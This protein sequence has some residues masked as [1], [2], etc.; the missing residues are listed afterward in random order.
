[1][2]PAQ[3]HRE[4]IDA[5][6]QAA[7]AEAAIPAPAAPPPAKKRPPVTEAPVVPAS[8]LDRPAGDIG[9]A[10]T[11]AKLRSPGAL[12][13]LRVEAGRLAAAANDNIDETA[14]AP[15]TG[16][17]GLIRLQLTEDKRRLKALE[18]IEA[19]VALKRELLSAYDDYCAIVLEAARQGHAPQDD[20]VAAIFMWRIDVGDFEGA[21]E[22]ADYLLTNRL[23]LPPPNVRSVATFLAEEV[24]EAAIKA[25]DAGKPFPLSAL[26][27]V[28]ILTDDRDMHDPV[29]AKLFKADG[30]IALLTAE[31]AKLAADAD[32]DTHAVAGLRE[33]ALADAKTAFTR[34]KELEPKIGVTKLLEKVDAAIAADAKAAA[35]QKKDQTQT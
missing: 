26:E 17:A 10:V 5:A 18:S 22:L 6:R 27:A 3:R 4:K 7:Q 16:P 31:A 35:E 21:V 29:R 20:V 23:A 19:K 24:A 2:T 13:R 34:A 12:K 14:P 8:A 25:A 32:G 28:H 11:L 1:M 30:R 9:R 15:D 33:R